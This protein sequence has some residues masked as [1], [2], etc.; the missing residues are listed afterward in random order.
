MISLKNKV[1]V[2]TGA[3][4]GIGRG[5]AELLAR[6]GAKVVVNDLGTSEAGEGSDESVAAQV[7]REITAAG[8]EAVANQD[9]VASVAG[10]KKSST[11]RSSISAAST[12][13]STTPASCAIG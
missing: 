10:G 1:A 8:G 4:R 13:S 3:G 6:Y 9:S 11:P 12:S 2:V 7:A 5:I